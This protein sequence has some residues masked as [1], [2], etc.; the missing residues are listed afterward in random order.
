M[1]DSKNSLLAPGQKNPR[2]NDLFH[3]P[4]KWTW[5]SRRK[6]CARAKRL[7]EEGRHKDA[8]SCICG[9]LWNGSPTTRNARPTSRSAWRGKRKFV[10]AEKLAKNVIRNNP[11]DAIAYYALGRV[12]LHRQPSGSAFQQPGKS[13]QP[14]HR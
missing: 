10:S 3:R 11:F 9:R 13:P 12:N 7:I 6:W 2:T 8:E 4:R 5:S 1:S 14:G